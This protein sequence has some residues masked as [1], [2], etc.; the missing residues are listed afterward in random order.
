MMAPAAEFYQ[1]LSDCLFGPDHHSNREFG[2]R[3]HDLL[4][5]YIRGYRLLHNH[6]RV[7]HSR[8]PAKRFARQV[9]RDRWC[10]LSHRWVVA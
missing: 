1:R 3:A 4:D 9:Y 5:I 10:L 8:L 2:G 6:D 7:A